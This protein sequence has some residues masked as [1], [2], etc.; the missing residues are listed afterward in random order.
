MSTFDLISLSW[1]RYLI[2]HV[3]IVS[4]NMFSL[5]L[6][7]YMTFWD[8]TQM[9]LHNWHWYG[10][11]FTWPLDRNNIITEIYLFTK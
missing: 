6:E 9:Q 2:H 5:R 8:M 7:C 10:I 3:G 11:T 4:N 1:I